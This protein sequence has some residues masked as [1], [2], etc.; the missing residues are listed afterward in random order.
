MECYAETL[1]KT[2]GHIACIT[3]KDTVIAVSGGS[4]KEFLEQNPDI[5]KEM[6]KIKDNT[7]V[8]IGFCAESE[9][10]IDNAKIKIQ[11]KG[12]DYIIANDIL[13][14]DTSSSISNIYGFEDMI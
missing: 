5:L 10:L 1:S 13:T 14:T 3:D 4:K 7:Q 2:T 9:N 8:I 11:N 6:G 12:C